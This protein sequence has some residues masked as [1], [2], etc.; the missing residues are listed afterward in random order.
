MA[1]SFG[2]LLADLRIERGMTATMLAKKVGVDPSYITRLEKGRRLPPGFQ[3]VTRISI[4]LDL[5]RDGTRA[6]EGA[7]VRCKLTNTLDGFQRPGRVK[8]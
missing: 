7:A 8:T 3:L 2:K 1:P 4:A 5:S 6:L